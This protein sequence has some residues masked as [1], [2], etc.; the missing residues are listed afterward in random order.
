MEVFAIFPAK[1]LSEEFAVIGFENETATAW[2]KTELSG[3]IEIEQDPIAPR[4]R[5]FETVGDGRF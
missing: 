1:L 5:A 3:D 4:V 2:I